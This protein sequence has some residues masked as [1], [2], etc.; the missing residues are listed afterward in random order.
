MCGIAGLV[1]LTSN[2]DLSEGEAVV[3]R[4]SG[5]LI[6]R[7]PDDDGIA[8]R[9]PVIPASRRLSIIDLSPAGHMPMID[10]S[11]RWAITYNGEVCNFEDHLTSAMQMLKSWERSDYALFGL[12]TLEIWGRI[13]IR[14]ERVEVLEEQ[15]CRLQ[16]GHGSKAR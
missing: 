2:R 10:A 4:M 1:F 13:H 8:V 9:E 16:D 15:I 5:R 6:H 3:R 12:L 14:R 11:A 7:G